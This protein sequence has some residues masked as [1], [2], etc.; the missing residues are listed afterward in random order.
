MWCILNFLTPF[1]K[2]DTEWRILHFKSVFSKGYGT[3]AQVLG[4]P[5]GVLMPTCSTKKFNSLLFPTDHQRSFPIMEFNV[6]SLQDFFSDFS[7]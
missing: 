3:A 6:C 4:M 1:A 7:S 2:I 5:R